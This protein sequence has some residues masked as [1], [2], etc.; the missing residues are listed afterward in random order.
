VIPRCFERVR[1]TPEH[2]QSIVADRGSLAMPRLRSETDR[3]TERN[4]RCL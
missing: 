3:P 2:T 1:K 4:D